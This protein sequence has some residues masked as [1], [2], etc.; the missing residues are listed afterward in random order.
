MAQFILA[1]NITMK[2]EGGY[3]ND[4]KDRGGETWKGISRKNFPDWPGWILIDRAKSDPAFPKNLSAVVTLQD[5]VLTFYKHNFW[6]KL[7][8]DQAQD[9][10]I[11][12]ELFDTGVNMGA[13]VASNF[14]QRTL[15]VTDRNQH[16]YSDLAVDGNVGP[17]TISVLN[18]HKSPDLILKVL[19][20]LQ[21][22]KYIV[23]A[24]ANPLQED[25]FAG[26]LS[27]VM[28]YCH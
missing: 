21:G 19:N 20:V 25:F 26:W 14:L 11:A 3:S 6:D 7:S 5:D 13:G 16:D 2:I 15:N 10:R 22:G 12:N 27:R 23:I 4:P 24:E 28:E 18:N 17:K 9:Q 8:L 1:Y